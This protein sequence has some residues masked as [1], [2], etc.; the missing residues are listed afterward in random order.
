ME[1]GKTKD[2]IRFEDVVNSEAFP[3][4]LL[5]MATILALIFA[6]TPLQK[7]YEYFLFE[8]KISE[9]FNIH[10]F[11]ND[12]L[13]AIFFLV[14]GCE[15]KRELVYGKLSSFKEA[16][17]PIISAVGGMVAPA[18]IFTLF[19]YK[20][21]FEIGV[22]IPL[23]TDIA[24]AIGIFSLLKSR[25]NPSLELFL[26]TLA[27]VDDLLSMVVIGVFYSSHIRIKG[28]IIAAILV[29]ILVLI[30]KLNKKN[31]LY[32]YI[33]VGLALWVA[34]FYSGVHSTLSGVILAFTIPVYSDEERDKDLNYKLQH[35]LEPFTNYIVLPLFAFSNTG[36]NLGGNLNLVKDYPLM[37]GIVA[38]LVIGKPLG[39]MTFGYL[40]NLF[41]IAKKPQ[42]AS[43]TD[44]LM[45]SVLAGIGFTMSLFVSE[46]AFANAEIE[47]NVAKVSILLSAIISTTLVYILTFSKRKKRRFQ[48]M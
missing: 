1:D 4:L 45:V 19:N 7:Y 31:K 17:F 33:I 39:I 26:L 41:G 37:I 20:V 27:V 25:L 14:V 35:I 18:L 13:M 2:K 22:G 6:N 48:K 8:L 21:G 42:D 3:G 28:L 47:M 5:L 30:N 43:W 24:F 16:S 44:V 10:L 46:I 15:I 36:I 38:G 32:P 12:F 9:E 34:I 23:S 40:G 29:G 11:I